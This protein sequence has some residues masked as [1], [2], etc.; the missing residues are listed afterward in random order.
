MK[1]CSSIYAKQRDGE[2]SILFESSHPI[3]FFWLMLL[4]A[5]SI[6]A[7]YEKLKSIPR[8]GNVDEINTGFGL[9]KLTAL[10][11]AAD[12]RD[13]V[14]QYYTVYLSLYDDWLYF[15][16]ISDFS[17]MKIYLDLYGTSLTHPTLEHFI[18]SLQKAVIC[19]DENRDAWYDDTVA[20]MCGRE[21]RNHNMPRFSDMSEAFREI[22]RKEL[23]GNFE[24]RKRLHKKRLSFS[25]IKC[26]L[27][28]TLLV[29]AIAAGFYFFMWK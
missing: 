25:K 6:A 19:F 14:R 4:D 26:V 20:G 10:I 1:N 24:N 15:M 12:R 7:L 13:Y 18:D 11:H 21:G 17:D 28:I 16:Q 22:S 9:D 23:S 27:F 2:E 8:R 29:A 5:N 3:P